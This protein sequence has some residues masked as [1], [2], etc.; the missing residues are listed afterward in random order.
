MA[1]ERP[2]TAIFCGND[3]MAL[4]CYEALKELGKRIPD[5]VSVIGFDDEEISGHLMP[6]L[7]TLKF[8]R[9]QMGSWA[10][11]RALAMASNR[12]P[13]YRLAKSEC[14]LVERASVAPPPT[15]RQRGRGKADALAH[16][17]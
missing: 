6:A 17:A 3:K 1:L 10:V 5:D 9:H 15:Q 12:E 14:E 7:T 2:P 16:T 4:G 13:T 11:E 8:P